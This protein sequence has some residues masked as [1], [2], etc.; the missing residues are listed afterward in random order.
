MGKRKIRFISQMKIKHLD[1]LKAMIPEQPNKETFD[2]MDKAGN[3]DGIVTL[4]EMKKFMGC[5]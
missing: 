4:K 1:K 3:G 2:K 5:E